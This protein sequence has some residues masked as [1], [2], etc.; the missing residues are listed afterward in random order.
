MGPVYRFGPHKELIGK[1]VKNLR[2][3]PL[4][5]W[6]ALPDERNAVK[7]YDPSLPTL[8]GLLQRGLTKRFGEDRV[9]AVAVDGVIEAVGWTFKDGSG[10]GPGYS[11]LLPP[12]SLRAGFNRVDIYMLEDD[13]R[14]LVQ[15]Y[16]GSKPLP[17]EVVEK[18]NRE[19]AE[20]A[21][22]L[23]T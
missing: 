11:I 6:R 9:L 1:R 8:R 12:D 19:R 5:R 16:D 20:R 15:V 4:A 17:P 7:N 21:A 18:Q 13:G 22:E 3:E 14:T 2:V 23:G 10:R